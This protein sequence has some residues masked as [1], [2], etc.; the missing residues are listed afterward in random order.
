M[1]HTFCPGIVCILDLFILFQGILSIVSAE[2]S[3]ERLKAEE[4]QFLNYLRSKQKSVKRKK[5]F[6]FPNCLSRRQTISKHTV[7]KHFQT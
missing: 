4:E 3:K 6:L 7:Q 5:S 1:C 2:E